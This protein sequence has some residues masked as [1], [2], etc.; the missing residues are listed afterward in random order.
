M[1]VD[2]RDFRFQLIRETFKRFSSLRLIRSKARAQVIQR[3]IDVVERVSYFMSDGRSE[4]PHHGGFFSLMQL[5]FQL[6]GPSQLRSHFIES[7]S[8]RSHLI[9][10]FRRH[11][12]AEVSGGNSARGDREVLN[13]SREL[14]HQNSGKKR[15][16]QK[17]NK[18]VA[19]RL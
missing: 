13:R 9:A 11:T 7:F 15:R 12:Y 19:Q 10:A 8:E 16:D 3:E 18:S 4:P 14:P 6:S 17:Q 1:R 5:R 2:S